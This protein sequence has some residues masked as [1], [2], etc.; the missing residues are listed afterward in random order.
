[1]TGGIPTRRPVVP[2]G[3]MTIGMADAAEIYARPRPVASVDDCYFYHTMDLPGH[4]LVQGDWDLRR[5]VDAYLGNVDFCR[6]RVLDLGTADGFL[7]FHME[8]QG[9]EV[10]S[11]DVSE[12]DRFDTVP[13]A[14]LQVPASDPTVATEADLAGIIP[15][16]NNA[17]WFSHHAFESGARLVHGDIYSL[18][19]EIGMVDISVFGAILLH[20][21]D[22]F[23]AL[24]RAV[25][26]TKET[27]VVTEGLGLLRLPPPLRWMRQALP[28]QL[29]RPVMRFMPD[30]HTSEGLHGWWRLTPEVVQ[31]FLGVLGF[32]RSEVSTHLQLFNGRRRRLFT[33][34]AHRTIPPSE[35]PMATS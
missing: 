26:L 28:S 13:F 1:M 3:H 6:K 21:R 16:M 10:V 25:G 5:H 19:K 9:A 35:E 32:E 4:G 24:T 7:S 22:P 34:V 17:Y 2:F 14:R 31:A 23:L 29:R 12:E 8:H 30:W 33:V 15:Q 20:T 11:Y 18:P 27:V